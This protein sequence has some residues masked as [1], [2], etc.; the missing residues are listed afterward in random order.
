VPTVQAAFALVALLALAAGVAGLSGRI[1]FSSPLVLTGVGLVVSFLPGVPDYQL[2]PELVLVGLLPPLLYATAIRTP[3]VTIRRHRRAIALLSVGLVGVTAVAVGAVARLVLGPGLPW[4]AAIALGAVV[5]PPDAVAAT[6]V[7][8]RIGLPRTVVTLLE[9]ESLLNDAT[10]LVTLRSA[11]VALGAGLSFGAISLTFLQAVLV[12]AGAGWLVAAVASPIRRRVLDPVL[13]TTLSLLV[14][15]V[16]YLLAESLHG[17]GVLGVVVAG[18]IL[19]H[20][21][22]EI[23]SATSR[24]TE[25]II[26]RTVQFLLES[27][28]FLLI[29]LQLRRLVEDARASQIANQT[30]VLL[31]LAVFATTVVVRLVWIFPA[32]YLPRL[33]PGVATGEPRPDPRGVLVLGWAG[34]RGVVTLAAAFGLPADVP[35]RQALVIAAFG[36]VAGTLLVQGGTLPAL[37]RVLRVAGPDPRQDALQQALVLQRAVDAGRERLRLEAARPDPGTGRPAS[38][39]VVDSLAGW[40]ERIAHAV[41]ERLAMSDPGAETPSR[42]FR[43]LRVAML[44]AERRVVVDVHRSGAVPAEV[45]EG[46]LERLDSEEA[47]LVAFAD[48]AATTAPSPLQTPAVSAGCEHLRGEP[49]LAV[50]DNPSGCTDCLAIDDP[51]WVALRMCVRCGHVACCDSSPHRHAFAH[52]RG[53]GHPVMRS[54]ELGENW[55]WCYVDTELG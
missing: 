48:G 25:R 29:G 43:R 47:M 26:W 24:T 23:Q 10:A 53:S 14:P 49:L 35:A 19:G 40:G 18:L 37:V 41:W 55:R 52:H 5:A 13:D 6:A 51:T 38:P 36:V 27:V 3:F 46:V 12:G 1:G 39:D 2:D 9:G 17:S 34:M 8:R 54:I 21:S 32:A 33:I 11:V 28:I 16:G 20:R 50:P 4:G 7:A 15:Y 22:P 44:D 31:C 42:A 30:I 45:L